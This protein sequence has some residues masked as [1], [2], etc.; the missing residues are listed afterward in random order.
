VPGI[1]YGSSLRSLTLVEQ[2]MKLRRKI[3]S[4]Y[5]NQNESLVTLVSFPRLGCSG[6]FLEPHHEPFGPESRSLFVPDEALNPHFA[7]NFPIFHDK[8]SQNL[9]ADCEEALPDHIYMDSS[10]FA[11]YLS[12]VDCRW[13]ALVECGDDRTKEERGLESRYDS[14]AYYISTDKAL[15]TE[16]NDLNAAYDPNIYEKLTDN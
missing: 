10:V 6:Q 7:L 15:K 1:P 8:K 3:V 2:N 16:Y 14:I 13:F 11:G 4:K 5:L 12:E 9:F